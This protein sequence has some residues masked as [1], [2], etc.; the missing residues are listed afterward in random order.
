[1]NNFYCR[2]QVLWCKHHGVCRFLCGSG[3]L[4][5]FE[6]TIYQLAL[7]VP[8]K[9]ISEG[10]DNHKITRLGYK[11][12]SSQTDFI[13]SYWAKFAQLSIFKGLRCQNKKI[14]TFNKVFFIISKSISCCS[15]WSLVYCIN[16]LKC[17]NPLTV[18]LLNL[19]LSIIDCYF[20]HDNS[21]FSRS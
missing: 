11:S 12:R 18:I 15:C 20:P 6:I 7:Y 16:I 14:F 5:Q 10:F 21:P 19:H 3:Q 2:L 13:N 17:N 9:V 4:F 8:C 1:M